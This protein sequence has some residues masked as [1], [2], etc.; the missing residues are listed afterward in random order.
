MKSVVFSLII[1]AS[2]FA[3]AQNI[4][5]FII[6]SLIFNVGDSLSYHPLKK[7]VFFIKTE[8]DTELTVFNSDDYCVTILFS[9]CDFN[10]GQN[11]IVYSSPSKLFLKH[12]DRKI[13]FENYIIHYV[14]DSCGVSNELIA[15][16]YPDSKLNYFEEILHLN[17]TSYQP[18]IP[19][20]YN[21]PDTANMQYG[22]GMR[23]R[24]IYSAPKDTTNFDF[25]YRNGVWVQ[26]LKKYYV[27]LPYVNDKL[28]G[29]A[30]IYYKNGSRYEIPFK[31]NKEIEGSQFY[32]RK[33]QKRNPGL[34]QTIVIPYCISECTILL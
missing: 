19:A 29:I 1:L 22:I 32:N 18:L 33:G 3:S 15:A 14:S 21:V 31:E 13:E 5:T 34:F 24:Q 20:L 28:N 23:T 17:D 9:V 6:D 27:E 10:K 26:Y 4:Q 2:Q 30:K 25:Q 7:S 8:K 11:E 16:V 12:H